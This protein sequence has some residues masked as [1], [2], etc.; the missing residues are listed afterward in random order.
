M[1]LS[2]TEIFICGPVISTRSFWSLVKKSQYRLS[3][4]FFSFLL[5]FWWRVR[6]V[7]QQQSKQQTQQVDTSWTKRQDEFS[8]TGAPFVCCWRKRFPYPSKQYNP[9][10]KGFFALLLQFRTCFW[11]ATSCLGETIIPFLGKKI[12]KVPG[13]NYLPVFFVVG[14]FGGG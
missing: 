8:F 13:I 2:E 6:N 1:K 10:Q 7:L 5:V 11:K 4:A 12:I 3:I 14:A 9:K